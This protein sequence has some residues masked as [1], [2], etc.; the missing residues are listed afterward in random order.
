M[1]LPEEL[2]G[3]NIFHDLEEYVKDKPIFFVGEGNWTFTLVFAGNK[4]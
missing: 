4:Y 1:E 2:E 3:L